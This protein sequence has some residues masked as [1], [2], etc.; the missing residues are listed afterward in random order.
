LPLPVLKKY[1]HPFGVF[2]DYDSK[3]LPIKNIIPKKEV[4]LYLYL[5]K[6]FCCL[7]VSQKTNYYGLKT[8]YLFFINEIVKK[9]RGNIYDI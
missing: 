5:S 2:G 1:R 3:K 8:I 4:L 9:E 6:L 7:A